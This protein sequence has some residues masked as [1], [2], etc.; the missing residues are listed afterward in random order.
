MIRLRRATLQDWALLLDWRND[1]I[2]REASHQAR[3]VQPDEHIAW[4]TDIL[5]DQARELY[6]AE[7]SGQVVGSVRAELTDGIYELS[8]SVAPM[9]RGRGVATR[10]VA[11]LTAQISAPIR[12]EIKAGN[13]ASARVAERAGMTFLQRV[14]DVLHYRRGAVP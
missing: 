6:L 3:L 4:L 11:L 14:G 7:E 2:T 10:M 8:W 9:A 13:L 5:N 1:P 12:A